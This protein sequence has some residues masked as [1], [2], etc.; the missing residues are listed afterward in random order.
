MGIWHIEK[1]RKK[2]DKIIYDGCVSC[3]NP[4]LIDNKC[5]VRPCVIEKKIDNCAYCSEYI[6]EKLKMRKRIE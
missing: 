4:Q 1:Y 3:E 5:P 2:Y 6:C